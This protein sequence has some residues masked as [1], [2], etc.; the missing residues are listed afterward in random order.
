MPRVPEKEKE[1]ERI[2][3]E[4]A[5]CN[6]RGNPTMDIVGYSCIDELPKE[7]S[8]LTKVRRINCHN[9]FRLSKL[10]DSF[11]DL[12]ERL[13]QLNLSYNNLSEFPLCL[14][15]LK[16]LT[17]L[18]LN[19]NN[20]QSLPTKVDQLKSL[21]TLYLDSNYIMAL[22]Y[23]IVHLKNLKYLYLENNP[24]TREDDTDPMDPPVDPTITYCAVTGE[25]LGD[26]TYSFVN[27]TDYAGNKRMP[28]HYV[29]GSEQA[30]D[31]VIEEKD[32][33][34]VDYWTL[35]YD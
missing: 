27:F 28:I 3:D 16:Y 1:T 11:G 18:D 8:H 31:M 13:E 17:R 6:A 15:R 14:C 35:K 32:H 29:C 33:E 30:R 19:N 24:L 26:T 7:I 25:E 21:E 20:I 23:T 9:N 4:I 2:K 34:V 5:S 12:Y 10:P 22:P